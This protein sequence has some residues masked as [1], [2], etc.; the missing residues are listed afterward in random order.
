MNSV[1]NGEFYANK[2]DERNDNKPIWYSS[3]QEEDIKIEWGITYYGASFAKYAFRSKNGSRYGY[4]NVTNATPTECNGNWI[5]NNGT[6]EGVD[7]QFVMYNCSYFTSRI[8]NCN[9][10]SYLKSIGITPF[11]YTCINNLTFQTHLQGTYYY[12]NVCL[13]G[14][15]VYN[16]TSSKFL[17]YSFD[18]SH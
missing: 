7:S 10:E 1:I 11:N 9:D 13:H 2:T 8:N 17:Y 18:D 12:N 16:Y 5:I 6:S 3:N 15:P 14:I 4:C